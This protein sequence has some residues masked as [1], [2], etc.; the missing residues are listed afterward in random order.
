METLSEAAPT[1]VTLDTSDNIT[2]LDATRADVET[3]LEALGGLQGA[4]FLVRQ[5]N[6][7]RINDSG[8]AFL[9]MVEAIAANPKVK[10]IV[11]VHTEG[12]PELD[13]KVA[14]V[15]IGE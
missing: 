3:Q 13:G 5:M 12:D 9:K 8:R 7:K 14:R 15:V 6:A 1:N 2:T 10:V 11:S 4:I